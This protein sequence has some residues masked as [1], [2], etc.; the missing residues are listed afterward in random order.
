M[1]PSGLL[2][3]DNWDFKALW[4]QIRETGATFKGVRFPTRDE[5]EQAWSRFQGLVHEVREKQNERRSK[6]DQRREASQKLRDS[7][8]RRAENALPDS[9]LGD[10]V[11]ALATGGLSVLLEM[12]VDALLGPYDK[13]K[14]EL[15][16]SSSVLRAAW[17]EFGSRKNELLREDKNTVFEAL[18]NEQQKLDNLWSEYKTERQ[19]ALDKFYGEKRRRHEQWRERTLGN[20]RKNQEREARLESVLAHK[21]SHLDGLYER[22]PGAWSDSYRER[23]AGWI[24]EE[25][26]AIRDIGGKIAEIRGW[27]SEDLAKLNS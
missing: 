17:D 26:S 13:R 25:V 3:G 5:H 24:E 4:S 2:G 14:Q 16:Q 19:A 21:R 6:F 12:T 9:G 18:K 10:L 7:L 22:L 1:I 8:I 23:V 20:I 27:I 15:L 11:I